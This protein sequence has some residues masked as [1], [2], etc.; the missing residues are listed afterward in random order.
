MDIPSVRA[1]SWDHS[2]YV[3]RDWCTGV[4]P[5]GGMLGRNFLIGF[6][7]MDFIGFFVLL[8]WL[9][10]GRSGICPLG[11]SRGLFSILR[12]EIGNFLGFA[13]FG[14]SFWGDV[15]GGMVLDLVPSL[16]GD[17]NLRVRAWRCPLCVH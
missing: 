9:L 8:G 14:S 10:R 1:R 13:D 4:V 11:L 3:D 2:E 12:C 17:I 16:W 7:C 15:C 5:N 6:V